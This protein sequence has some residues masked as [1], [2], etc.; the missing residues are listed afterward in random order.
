MLWQCT[1]P[2]RTRA[3]GGFDGG[4]RASSRARRRRFSER[5]P[6][7]PTAPCPLSPLPHLSPLH[8]Q[9]VLDLVQRARGGIPFYLLLWLLIGGSSGLHRAA[10][11]FFSITSALFAARKLAR[12]AFEPRMA[13]LA[14]RKPQQAR[15]V[16]L[17]LLLSKPTLWGLSMASTAAGSLFQSTAPRRLLRWL[18]RC[19]RCPNRRPASPGAREHRRR[20][21]RHPVAGSGALEGLGS[22]RDAKCSSQ[23]TAPN[24]APAAAVTPIASAPQKVTRQMP[25][26]RPAPPARADR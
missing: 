26:Q 13:E 20:S 24:S 3:R 10:P 21:R 14:L 8:R 16:C 11:V 19:R 5:D 6:S 7:R 18:S 4:P 2:A 15:G 25:R 12:L 17:V 23:A 1:L 22:G 9:A